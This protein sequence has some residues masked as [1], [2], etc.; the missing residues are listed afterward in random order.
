MK[1]TT[2]SGTVYEFTKDGNKVR[3]LIRRNDIDPES[4]VERAKLDLD[5]RWRELFSP[6]E[7]KVGVGMTMPYLEEGAIDV[8]LTSPVVGIEP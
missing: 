4:E 2:Q 5:G 1:V 8:H 7:P 3:R 6:V